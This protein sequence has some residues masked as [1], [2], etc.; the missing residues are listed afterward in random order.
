MH[1]LAVRYGQDWT[2]HEEGGRLVYQDDSGLLDLP[3][4][5]LPGRHQIIN[6]GVAIAT[7]RTL[8]DI[9]IPESAMETG[10]SAVRWPARLQRLTIGPVVDVTE[11]N[12]ELWLD[13]GHNPAAGEAI[14]SALGEFE[15]RDPRPTHL[16]LGMMNQKD[17]G[18]FLKPFLG[19]A[20]SVICIPIP[21][22][23][24]A[25]DPPALAAQAEILGFETGTADN[26]IN[27]A[28][29][30]AGR[31]SGPQRILICGSLYLAGHVLAGNG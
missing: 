2:V 5:H 9:K 24:N 31:A 17:T 1:A 18:G 10:M 26:T 22:E 25:A 21:G 14:A 30:I 13:G 19:L 7:L 16:I 6:A 28:R 23:I 29:I 8:Q 12:C 4:P 20:R 27:A 11:G 15:E 3:L